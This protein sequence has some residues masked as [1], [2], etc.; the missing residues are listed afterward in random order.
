MCYALVPSSRSRRRRNLQAVFGG[1]DEEPAQHR[2]GHRRR[3]RGTI[4]GGLKPLGKETLQARRRHQHQEL[5][6]RSPGVS[7]AM[8][9]ATREVNAIPGR[10]LESL[11]ADLDGERPLLHVK[12]LLLAPMEV[13]WCTS[14]GWDGYLGE[15]ECASGLVAGEQ[16]PD[17]ISRTPIR[18]A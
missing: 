5:R 11:A 15:E 16:K 18:R 9:D 4:V 6:L 8:H 14:S 7:E 10:S 12:R 3:S 13:R 17:L 2:F 1:G